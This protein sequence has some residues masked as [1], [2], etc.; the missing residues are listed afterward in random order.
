MVDY[1]T[2]SPLANGVP[3]LARAQSRLVVNATGTAIP[4][5]KPVRLSPTGMQ[6]IDVSDENQ[7]NAIAGITRTLI[8]NAGQGELVSG[9]IIEDIG[10]I[11]TVGDVFYVDKAGDLTNVKPSIGINSFVAGDWV[12]RVGVLASNNV[13]PVLFDLLVNINIVGAL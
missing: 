12:I 9:G 13:N 2:Y 5:G 10:A 1:M 8:N 3:A 7:A 11:G 4:K 6:L